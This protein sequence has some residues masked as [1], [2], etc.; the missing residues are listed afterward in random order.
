M[1]W[2]ANIKIEGGR[3][4]VTN[5]S[6]VN[7]PEHTKQYEAALLALDSLVASGSFGE[8]KDFAVTFSGHGNPNHEPVSGWSNDCIAISIYQVG[9]PV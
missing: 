9:D 8:G 3:T 1:S 4:V 7:T 2:G 6:G 5:L